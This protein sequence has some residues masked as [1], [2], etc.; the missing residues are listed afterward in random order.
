MSVH[1]S[2]AAGCEP[3]CHGCRHRSLTLAA[4]LAQKQHYL[5]RALAPWQDRLEPVRSAGESA[6]YGYRDRVTLNARWDAHTGWRFGLVR[7][8]ELIAIHDCP[9]HTPRVNRLLELLR[10]RLPPSDVLALAYVH[11]AGAQATLI[12]KSRTVTPTL[13][14]PLVEAI[15]RSGLEGLWL[16]CHPAA[17]RKL[18]ARSGWQL[19]W[20]RAE[21]VGHGGLVHG[22]TSF[23]QL[24]PALHAQSLA[25][26]VEHLQPR[27]D[28]AVL[29]LYC[30]LG[31]SLHAWTAAGAAALG[32]E[33]GGDAVACARRNAPRATVLRGTCVQ[34][35][36]QVR[37]WWHSAPGE[38]L[39][40]VNPPR[41]G[42]ETD[43]LL[44]VAAELRPVRVAYLSCSAGT[45]ARDLA[46][47]EARG[48]TVDRI[49][50]YDFF[51]G[52]HHVECLALLHLDDT[53]GATATR[54]PLR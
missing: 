27:G 8:D 51:P 53:G 48:Y 25:S 26:A 40:Y 2:I 28:S 9:V 3:T 14:A 50:P 1:Q 44:A 52:T 4:S 32:I 15:A 22:P 34:R 29:D 7:R 23:Q 54:G 45:L 30:G 39:A 41:S 33:L 35:L 42:L 16:H 5:E 11:V 21:S 46:E 18:F 43:L 12:V 37:E 24:L 17:G 36:P 6:R 49:V 19:L 38:H 47:F 13:L 31:A 10:E 20:G